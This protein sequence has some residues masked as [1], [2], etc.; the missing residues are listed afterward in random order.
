MK[1]PSLTVISRRLGLVATILT[2]LALATTAYAGTLTVT[3]GP[4]LTPS[5]AFQN[6]TLT[7]QTLNNA[8][9]VRE[10]GKVTVTV[11]DA[12]SGSASISFTGNYAATP[13]DLASVAYSF[14]VDSND[15]R[16]ISYDVV[17]TATINGATQRFNSS[18]LIT[19]GVNQYTANA[20]AAAPF[21]AASMG[22]FSG[23]LTLKA[24]ITLPRPADAS[25]TASPSAAAPG[26]LDLTI[27]QGDFA[28]TGGTPPTVTPSQLRNIS[29]RA[30]IMGGNQDAIAGFII[31]GDIPKR[32][33]VRGIGPSL[34][35]YVPTKLGD[36][37]LNLMQLNSSGAVPVAMNNNWKDTQQA[38]IEATGLAPTKDLESAIVATLNPGSYTAQLSG[39]VVFPGGSTAG[40]ASDPS[41][42]IGLVEVYD[43]DAASLSRVGNMSTRAMVQTGDDVLIGGIIVGGTNN[44]LFIVRAIGPSMRAT[45]PGALLDPNL[46]LHDTNGNMIAFNDD[47]QL[48]PNANQIPS[49][50]QPTDSKESALSRDLAPGNYTAIVR[51]KAG[52]TGV[53]LV[54]FYL[55]PRA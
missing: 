12:F 11:P 38:E 36:P 44:G 29:S 48:D 27:A 32:V 42:G 41:V 49:N 46:S 47:W 23:T 16:I 25:Y 6:S 22:T 33:I 28:L 19:Q 2:T 5:T 14:T 26:T 20:T 40:I 10:S 8:S 50:L 53:G 17:G 52:A 55:V 1:F 15:S 43:L 31:T 7:V 39:N 9:L 37:S 21:P 24:T 30:L 45:I 3:S 13:G 18:G 51:G 34:P 4:T 54:E 35:D